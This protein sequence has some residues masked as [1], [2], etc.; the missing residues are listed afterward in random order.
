MG[1]RLSMMIA[2]RINLHC[3]MLELQRDKKRPV[4][5]HR[6]FA[7]T[8][9]FAHFIVGITMTALLVFHELFYL[10][11]GVFL[12]YLLTLGLVAGMTRRLDWC[13]NVLGILF[14]VMS[15]AAAFFITHVNP[16]LTLDHPPMLSRGV[17]PIWGA[18]VCIGYFAGGG[19]MIM[20]Y[21]LRRAT[22]LGFKLWESS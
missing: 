10:S 20:S 21:R 18:V 5:E 7:R 8:V 16:A 17:L 14:L 3:F 12:W 11:I 15:L 22:M 19:L 13:R 4:V 1:V 2:T 6:S 9:V